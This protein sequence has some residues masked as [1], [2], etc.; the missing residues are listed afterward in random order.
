MGEDTCEY[1]LGHLSIF[2]SE[3]E[4]FAICEFIVFVLVVSWV[5]HLQ[6]ISSDS[7]YMHNASKI[8]FPI[9]KTLLILIGL[10]SLFQALVV[11]LYTRYKGYSE[12]NLSFTVEHVFALLFGL[13]AGLS[14][15]VLEG[16]LVKHTATSLTCVTFLLPFSHTL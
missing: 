15:F 7:M 4:I 11:V 3:W 5:G 2:R 14:G 12:A 6:D 13:S 9:H 8:I 16:R 1:F 10:F